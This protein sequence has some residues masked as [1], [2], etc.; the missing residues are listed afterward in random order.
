MGNVKTDDGLVHLVCIAE[1][2][3]NYGKTHCSEDFGIQPSYVTRHK[4]PLVAWVLA[5]DEDP[6]CFACITLEA[7]K[8]V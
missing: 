5:T 6:T 4:E 2:M 8:R 7:R 3:L 1:E